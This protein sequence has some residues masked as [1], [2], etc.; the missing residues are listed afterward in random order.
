M[1]SSLTKRTFSVS[2]KHIYLF[3]LI[4]SSLYLLTINNH[5]SPFT[6]N[7]RYMV[8]AKSIAQGSGYARI[9][10]PISIPQTFYPP[11][12]PFIL[13][14]IIKILPF[15]LATNLVVFKM[16]SLITTV[17]ALLVLYG[18]IKRQVDSATAV[19]ATLLTSISPLIFEFSTVELTE[20]VY[21][22]L[23]LL[24]IFFMQKF[25]E[26]SSKKYLFGAIV[27]AVFAYHIR[28]AGIVLLPAML[29]FLFA[30]R[31][32][33]PTSVVLMSYLALI[34][35]WNI[36]NYLMGGAGNGS[37]FQH[38]I[39]KDVV[40]PEL[41]MLSI[42]DHLSRIWTNLLAY[43][44]F[45]LWDKLMF[46]FFE[47]LSNPLVLITLIISSFIIAGFIIRLK[48]G[49]GLTEIYVSM[50]LGLFLL[51]PAFDTRYMHPIV[52]FIV[53]YFVLGARSLG[54]K[55][56]GTY[57]YL[58]GS[59]AIVS[60]VIA[61]SMIANNFSHG[62]LT[63]KHD[64][65]Y[66]A[67]KW[68]K[69]NSLPSNLILSARPETTFLLSGRRAKT[70]RDDIFYTDISLVGFFNY[71]IIDS[72]YP[73]DLHRYHVVGLIKRNP[74]VFTLI[75]SSGGIVRVYKINGSPLW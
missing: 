14:I 65:F 43:L 20:G 39:Y 62:G 70:Y 15:S 52:P 68:L 28:S 75:Y 51:W 3:A 23:S 9:H 46:N 27:V 42:A 8:L 58:T 66:K 67:N 17:L 2:R 74:Q 73:S 25:A 33:W 48:K 60:L 64:H 18:L 7:T 38:L 16:F 47:A 45:G 24:V 19:T 11:G 54:E 61:G 71:I 63:P 30:K 53:L 57:F 49:V 35:P 59:Y 6:D 34:L 32:I 13:A 31:K 55:M 40:H 36:R 72:F 1:M 56:S 41:G 50:Y 5:I 10:E 12:Y 69:N 21:L 44:T 26:E 37:Y 4:V 29:V 22:V